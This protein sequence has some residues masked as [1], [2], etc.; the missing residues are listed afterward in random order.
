MTYRLRIEAGKGDSRKPTT[1]LGGTKVD[2]TLRFYI[3][4]GESACREKKGGLGSTLLGIFKNTRIMKSFTRP[5]AFR[6]VC[7]SLNHLSFYG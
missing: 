2:E 6:H 4:N 7:A 5:S 1:I 3:E